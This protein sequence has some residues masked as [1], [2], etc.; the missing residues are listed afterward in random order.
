M[1]DRRA[2][3][4]WRRLSVWSGEAAESLIVLSSVLYEPYF[5]LNHDRTCV[6]RM[7]L[8]LVMPL[9]P[10]MPIGAAGLTDDQFGLERDRRAGHGLAT[11]L[12]QQQSSRE[13]AHFIVGLAQA[14][15]GGSAICAQGGSS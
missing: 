15:N 1:L 7:R 10:A 9:A 14:V 5:L 11:D 4:P 13:S 2:Q 3:G 6:V 8:I 12:P